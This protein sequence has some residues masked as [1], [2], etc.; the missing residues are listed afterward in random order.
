MEMTES[1]KKL[2]RRVR[3]EINRTRCLIEDAE[4]LFRVAP[5]YVVAQRMPPDQKDDQADR[6][7]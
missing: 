4:A 2:R 6:L 1:I 7:D 5:G 3:E